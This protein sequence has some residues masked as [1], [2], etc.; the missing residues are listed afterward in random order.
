MFPRPLGIT[1]Q[2]LSYIITILSTIVTK[3]AL[4]RFNDQ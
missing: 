2:R 1:N 4:S 3:D